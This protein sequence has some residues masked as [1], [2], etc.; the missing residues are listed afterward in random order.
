M[1]MYI[2]EDFI[3]SSSSWNER[4]QDCVVLCGFLQLWRRVG[5][6]G[7]AAGLGELDALTQLTV[8]HF[9]LVLLPSHLYCIPDMFC[10]YRFVCDIKERKE[11][12]YDFLWSNLCVSCF[13]TRPRLKEAFFN[14]FNLQWHFPHWIVFFFF[15]V[16][17]AEQR[18][19]PCLL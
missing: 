10:C 8:D 16:L 4:L 1:A 12:K 6:E 13:P 5:F 7:E 15:L 9:P 11:G 18:E 19:A 14:Q 17:Y 3:S 2:M